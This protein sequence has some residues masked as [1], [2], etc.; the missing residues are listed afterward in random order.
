[1]FLDMYH[2]FTVLDIDA[3]FKVSGRPGGK[4]SAGHSM[5]LRTWFYFGFKR[6]YNLSN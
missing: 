2:L 1:M 6:S 4:G 3:T 5:R